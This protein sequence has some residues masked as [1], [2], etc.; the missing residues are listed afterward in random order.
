ML[1]QL[2]EMLAHGNKKTAGPL[3]SAC[4]IVTQLVITVGAARTGKL[5]GV[6]GRRP[7][8]LVGF[9]VLVIRGCLY[10]VVRGEIALIAVQVLDGVVNLI[11]GVVSALVIADRTRGTGRFNLAQGALASSVGIGAALSTTLGGYLIG[12]FGYNVSFLGLAAVGLAAFILLLTLFPETKSG[13]DKPIAG[14]NLAL[15]EAD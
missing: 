5:A 2:G 10:T 9:G 11:F 8:L 15:S 13:T 4:V 6:M 14:A 1:P 12:H 3:M 7:L